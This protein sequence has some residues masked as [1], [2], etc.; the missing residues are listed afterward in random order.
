VSA[1][2]QSTGRRARGT[3]A[4]FLA[5]ALLAS[6]AILGGTARADG[7]LEPIRLVYRAG[8]GCP[9]EEEFLDK[10]RRWAPGVRVAGDDVAS[11]LFTVTVG[12]NGGRRGRLRIASGT[13][14]SGPTGEREVGGQNCGE[15]ARVLAF[16][17]ALAVDPTLATSARSSE[18]PSETAPSSTA[19]QSSSARGTPP[20]AS[21]QVAAAESRVPRDEPT[22]TPDSWMAGAHA[23]ATSAR[24]PT[25]TVGGG[26]WVERAWRAGVFAPSVRLGGEVGT[27]EP[28]LA[29]AAQVTFWSAVAIAE[30][31]PTQWTVLALTVRPCARTEAGERIAAGHDIPGARTAMRPWVAVAAALHVQFRVAWRLFADLSGQA[32]FP[33]IR[34]RVYLAPDILIDQ[35]PPFGGGGE[36]GVGVEFP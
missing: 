18:H 3:A 29:D 20:L 25:V 9:T 12:E 23:F 31:C 32:L 11:R 27:S 2:R 33:L 6:A 10:V 35:V 17:V 24:A 36:I 14:E 13:E 16:A 30:A 5:S 7:A 28:V 22:R 8:P 1:H 34:D 4:W 15:V 21:S 19:P 26:A